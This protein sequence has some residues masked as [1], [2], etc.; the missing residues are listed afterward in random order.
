MT[1]SREDYLV[2]VLTGEASLT[3]E[4]QDRERFE[5]IKRT[6]C[7]GSNDDE[8]ALF[9]AFVQRHHL[10][11]LKKHVY[12]IKRWDKKENRYIM[13]FGIT[14]DGYR[15]MTARSGKYQG[16][17]G[18][19]WCGPEGKWLEFW[20]SQDPPVASKVGILIKDYTA[21]VWGVATYKEFA[22][23][24]K[25][26]H[27]T[28]M[29]QK[30]PANQLAKCAEVQAHRKALPQDFDLEGVEVVPYINNELS[31]NDAPDIINEEILEAE[32]KQAP[33]SVTVRPY[34]PDQLKA[35]IA[36]VAAAQIGKE[37]GDKRGQVTKALKDFFMDAER[38]NEF[39]KW[40]CDG[41]LQEIGDSLIVAMHAWLQPRF[42][43]TAAAFVIDKV[44]V[45]EIDNWAASYEEAQEST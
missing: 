40:L 33:P 2:S 8:F 15:S 20:V 18:P 38:A 30:M 22:Q 37:A 7:K 3:K 27:I 11:P 32:V 41:T 35:R 12:P 16:Q 31:V 44:A 4:E 17:L 45:Q 25:D 43:D 9:I 10:D 6:I 19:F 42:D 14:V 23:T 34:S 5:L 29:W 28:G 39:T 24:D 13:S 36:E 26:G 1:E 21:P